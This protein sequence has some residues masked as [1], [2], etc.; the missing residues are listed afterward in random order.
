MGMDVYGKAPTSK[1]GKYFRNNVWWWRPLWDYCLE[2]VPVARKVE[3]GHS[4]DGDGLDAADAKQLGLALLKEIGEGRTETHS[5]SRAAKLAKLPRERCW[6]CHGTGVRKNSTSP[7]TGETFD[8]EGLRLVARGSDEARALIAQR[9]ADGKENAETRWDDG[10][11]L[12]EK[13]HPRAGQTG[14]C[15]AC[16]GVGS[17]RAWDSNYPFS[18][19]NVREF[20][21]FLIDSG[22]FEIS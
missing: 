18:V 3:N 12:V 19:D 13:D 14:W 20:A 10:V 2:T 22:G 4:N 1:R 11:L 5:R 9:K 15:N 7:I 16:N 6:I 17:K 21:A 8:S